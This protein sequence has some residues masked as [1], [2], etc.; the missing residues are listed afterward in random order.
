M[1]EGDVASGSGCAGCLTLTWLCIFGELRCE[2]FYVNNGC[3][4]RA[5]ETVHDFF[6]NSRRISF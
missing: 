3:T 2:L 6:L 1:L 5:S 4:K